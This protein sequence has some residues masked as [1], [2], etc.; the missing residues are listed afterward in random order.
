MAM[1][2]LPQIVC[3]AGT[4]A[5]NSADLDVSRGSGYMVRI[6]GAAEL[7]GAETAN[8]EYKDNAGTYRVLTARGADG[9]IYTEGCTTT[10]RVCYIRQS[11]TYRIAKS[12]TVGSVG[13]EVVPISTC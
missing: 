9:T 8:V 12:A 11:G 10:C 1:N 2:E 3:A 4:G 13:V 6:F 7:A 5:V